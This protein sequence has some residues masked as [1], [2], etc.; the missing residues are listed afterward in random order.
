MQLYGEAMQPDETTVDV[1]KS[2]KHGERVAYSR[3]SLWNLLLIVGLALGPIA[4]STTKS[5]STGPVHSPHSTNAT[6][7]LN[8]GKKW[9]VV[10][11]MMVHIRNLEK[12]VQDFESTP[13]QDHA[14]LASTI[15]ENLGRLVTNCTMEGK[16]HDELHKWLMPFLRLT[17]DYSKATDPRVQQEEFQEIKNALAVFNAHFE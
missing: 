1:I 6:L 5:G 13:G 14:A 4:C 7:E 17:A 10:K 15:Q 2:P 11:P 3:K 16:A 12:A 8:D 9:V